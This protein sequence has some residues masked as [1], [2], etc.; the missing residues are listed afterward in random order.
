MPTPP[1]VDTVVTAAQMLWRSAAEFADC[2]CITD[3]DAPGGPRTLSYAQLAETVARVAGGFTALG[4]RPGDRVALLLHNSIAYVTSFLAASAAGLV[5]VPLNV[6]LLGSDYEHMLADSGS[7]ILITTSEFIERIPELAART[8]L[9]LIAADGGNSA[10]GA[11]DELGGRPLDEPAGRE[12]SAPASLMY[13]SGTTGLPKAVVLSDRSWAAIAGRAIGV[14]GMADNEVTLHA[15]PLTHGAG[16]LLLP[17]LMLGGHNV[18]CKSFSGEAALEILDDY[19]ITGAFLVP[20]MIRML[21]DATPA[22][23]LAPRTLRRVY[24]A[25]SPIDPATFRE[26]TQA[27]DGRLVQSF[28]QMESPMFFTVLDSDDHRRAVRDVS[29]PLSRSAGRRLPGVDLRIVDEEG[30]EAVP[31]QPGEILARAPQTMN[32]YWNRPEAT[33][34]ALADGW[35]HTGDVG[36]L[37]KAGYLYIVDRKKDMIVTGGS[38][39]Y[40]REVEQALLE[41]PQVK[42]AAVIGTPHRIWG[43]AVTA[44]LVPAGHDRDAGA[45]IAACR[46]KLA[47]YRVPKRVEWVESLPRNA[48]GKVLKQQLRERF[49]AEA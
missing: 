14:L 10:Y 48:Y 37:D 24:Y 13:T 29:S 8:E 12:P 42:D 33:A 45:V 43:E 7:R 21:L 44:V 49:S 6:R 35:L 5:A 15:A 22:G 23:W 16:F 47:G 11:L 18:V 9:T 40:A 36:Y 1:E 34:Q 46:A 28:A 17:T 20:S 25:G 26:A 32:G 3:L 41:L 30:H 19:G 2:P 27:F 4:A 39:V 38:N 31:G